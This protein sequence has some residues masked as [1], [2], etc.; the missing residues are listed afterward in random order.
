MPQHT[1]KH[2]RLHVGDAE[3][4]RKAT[5]LEL[6]YDLIYVATVTALGTRLSQD[7]SLEGVLAFA[8][9]FVPVWWS[10][11]GTTFYANRFDSDDAFHR[12][13]VFLKILG[14]SLMAVSVHDALGETAPQFAIGYALVSFVLV[15][16]YLRARYHIKA[17]HALAT[18]HAI[19]FGLAGAAWLASAILPSPAR[20]IMWGLGLLIDFATPLSP[21]SAPAQ[22]ELPTSPR[23]LPERFGLFTIIVLGEA[24][25]RV[26]SGLAGRSLALDSLL[27]DAPGL[28]IA[29]SLWWIYFDNV[30]ETQVKWEG[31]RAQIWLYMHLPLQLGL[32]AFGVGIY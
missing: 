19:G 24:S 1:I 3:E 30:A 6:F 11:V 32:A 14:V 27:G 9:L 10:W 29:G 4:T 18:R 22:D 25:A 20:F 7:V 23:H 28:L 21:R 31:I 16:M 12:G 5:W 26:I 2:P 8:V 15:L 13:L 17:A